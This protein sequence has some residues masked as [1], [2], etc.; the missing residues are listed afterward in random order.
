MVEIGVALGMIAP[1]Y[2]LA[3][4]LI[5]VFVFIALF[6]TEQK[7]KV[8]LFPWKLVFFAL[9]VFIVEEVLTIL[10][11]MGII[12]IPIHINAFFELVMISVFIYALLLQKEYARKRFG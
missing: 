4:V 10:R 6:R 3:M 5:A 8:F 1:Y 12:D 7:A 11:A 2:N 9:L